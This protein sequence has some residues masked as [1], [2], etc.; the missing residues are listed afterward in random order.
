MLHRRVTLIDPTTVVRYGV[1]EIL[2]AALRRETVKISLSRDI[3]SRVS[4]MLSS[5]TVQRMLSSRTVQSVLCSGTVQSM[6]CSGTV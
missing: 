1:Y 5:G 6:L 4:T 3:T 2:A